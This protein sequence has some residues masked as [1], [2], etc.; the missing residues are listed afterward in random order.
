[1]SLFDLVLSSRRA[2]GPRPL[3]PPAFLCV[4]HSMTPCITLYANRSYR[5]EYARKYAGASASIRAI[6]MDL[7]GDTAPVDQA[8]F[9]HALSPAPYAGLADNRL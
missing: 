6:F 4:A 2:S 3:V 8:R 9:G 5:C 1:M 7:D